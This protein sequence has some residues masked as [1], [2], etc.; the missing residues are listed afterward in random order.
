[1][2]RFYY[3]GDHIGNSKPKIS[4]P[5]D[6]IFLPFKVFHGV[7]DGIPPGNLLRV[8]VVVHVE[9]RELHLAYLPQR[10]TLDVV[11]QHGLWACEDDSIGM[12]LLFSEF[13]LDQ[14]RQEF[15]LALLIGKARYID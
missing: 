7:S 12:V 15:R 1:M 5:A 9:N 11:L 14:I 4:G 3:A 10:L 6:G 2:S 13:F 8:E